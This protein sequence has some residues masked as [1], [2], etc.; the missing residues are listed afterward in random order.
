MAYRRYFV[1]IKYNG[2]AYHGWQFQPHSISVQ[3]TIETEMSK[4]LREKV[5]I[6][7]C[8]RTDTGVHADQYY[9][10]FDAPE[11]IDTDRLMFKLNGMLPSDI[12]FHEIIPVDDKA[13]ARF[14]ARYRQYRYEMHLD[15]NP[16]LTDYSWYYPY[17]KLDFVKMRTAAELLMNYDDFPMFCKKGS[18]VKTFICQIFDVSLDYNPETRK[19][20]FKI[21]ANRFLRT[22]IRR[23][24]GTLVQIGR[25]QMSLEEFEN[26][27]TEKKE[28]PHIKMAPPQGLYLCQVDYEYIHG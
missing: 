22:M 8:G 18:D 24:V 16:F 10:H 3:E 19:M 13:H 11:D 17:H 9:F 5:S 23:I 15:K 2:T 7:G 20:L 21:G 28:I 4:I 6:I 14:D 27:L 12:S 25:G 1:R 26:I